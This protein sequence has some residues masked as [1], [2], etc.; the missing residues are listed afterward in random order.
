[1]SG[2]TLPG[3]LLAND[4]FTS[5]IHLPD[6]S[7]ICK[8]PDFRLAR[9]DLSPLSAISA[10]LSSDWDARAISDTV[11]ERPDPNKIASI[12]VG[13]ASFSIFNPPLISLGDEASPIECRSHFP[14][15]VGH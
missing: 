13:R 3:I 11:I 10:S 12:T 7:D 2:L 1:M 15:D 6:I 9:V 4:G 14:L 5:I 8:A